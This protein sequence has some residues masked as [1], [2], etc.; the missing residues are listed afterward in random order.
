MNLSPNEVFGI[1]RL[2]VGHRVAV[3]QQEHLLFADRQLVQDQGDTWRKFASDVHVASL[4]S[5]AKVSGR[6]GLHTVPELRAKAQ[7]I[8][9][10]RSNA[11]EA[12]HGLDSEESQAGSED[13]LDEMDG[14]QSAN[15]PRHTAAVSAK[16][17]SLSATV[18]TPKVKRT[19]KKNKTADETDEISSTGAVA[20]SLGDLSR[21]DPEMA[22]VA[23]KH[24]SVTGRP[25]SGSLANL[26]IR[27]FLQGEKLG[28]FLNGVSGSGSQGLLSVRPSKCLHQNVLE[29]DPPF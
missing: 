7:A 24:E 18:A 22:V 5:G 12:H 27:R 4:P 14:S 15:A 16:V 3:E 8:Q 28:H 25:S 2:Q 21:V 6:P 13:L 29:G 10:A 26:Q 11:V 9:E 17:G 19:P 23:F 20:R 1:R